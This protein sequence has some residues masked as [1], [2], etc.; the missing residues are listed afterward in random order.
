LLGKTSHDFTQEKAGRVSSLIQRKFSPSCVTGMQ[1]GVIKEEIQKVL[2]FSLDKNKAPGPDG[3]SAGFFRRDWPVVGAKVC[4]AIMEFFDSGKLLKEVNATILTLVLKKKNRSSIGDYR[5][6]SCCNLVCKCIT[7]ILANSLIS[8]LEDVI[9]SNQGAFTPKRSIAENILL[10]QELVCNY[11]K[12]KGNPR[13]SLK[14][15]LMKAYDSL[16]WDYILHCLSCFGAPLKYVAWIRECITSPSYSIALNGSLVGYFQGRKGLRKGD[17]MS[18]YLFV[19]AM[20]GLSL[21]L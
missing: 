1:A 7:K 4:E 6:I 5:P 21:L 17:P 9:S 20:E 14:V 11:Q 13:C 8:G 15:D 12:E 18:P 10:A 19:L 3:F 16:R 2:M